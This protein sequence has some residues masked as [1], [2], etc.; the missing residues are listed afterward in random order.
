VEARGSFTI[1]NSV[2]FSVVKEHDE[3]RQALLPPSAIAT[4]LVSYTECAK[5]GTAM[6]TEYENSKP[7]MAPWM[8]QVGNMP[9]WNLG[10]DW[11]RVTG[12]KLPT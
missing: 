6:H 9:G 3:M 8:S 12:P 2:L 1:A 5:R 10:I 7:P 11:T 4:N